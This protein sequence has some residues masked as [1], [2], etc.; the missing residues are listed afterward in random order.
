MRVLHLGPSLALGGTEA[1]ADLLDDLARA[2]G[3]A[4]SVDLPFDRERPPGALS[5]ARWIAWALR[6]RDA[7]VMHAHL[8]WPDRLGAALLAARDRPLVITSHLLPDGDHWPRDRITALDAR[9]MLRLAA[10]RPRTVFVTL[11]LRD[12]DRLADFGVASTVIRNAPPFPRAAQAPC[13]WPASG[14]RIASVGRL[15]P[16]KGFDR[17]LRALADPSLAGLPWH[18]AIAGDGPQRAELEALRD[19]LGLRARV[20]FAGAR[21]PL[22]VLGGASVFV[23]PSRAEGMPLSPLEALEAGVPVLLSDIAPH[24]ELLGGVPGSLLPAD[25]T[26]WPDALRARLATG[27]DPALLEVQRAVLGGDPR[28]RCWRETVSCYEA[29]RARWA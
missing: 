7:D 9:L 6:R 12:R 18:W 26:R 21:P 16:Q 2:H 15:H 13:A 25:D 29:V 8:A 1:V 11:S 27:T 5:R 3:H 19:D 23:A 28:E 22:D 17:M 24:R 14:M 4:S 10:R 20:T